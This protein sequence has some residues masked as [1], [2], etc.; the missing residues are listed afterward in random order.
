MKKILL[1]TTVLVGTAGFA[2]AEVSLSGNARMGV[3]YDEGN[4]NNEVAFNSRV[5]ANVTMSGET[6]GGLSFGGTFGIHDAGDAADGL[7]GTV[8]ISGAF[9]KLAMGDTSSAAE[10]AVGDFVELGYAG[11]GAGNENTFISTGDNEMALYTYSAGAITFMASVGQPDNTDPNPLT[12]VNENVGGDNTTYSVAV[13][14]DTDA[15][16]VALGY[17]DIGAV[18]HIIGAA[19]ATFSG[20]TVKAVYGTANDIDFDQYGLGMSYKMDAMTLEAYYRTTDD[21]G[22]DADYY[23]IG[24]E[25]D[26][27]GGAT[28]AGGI[29]DA[30]GDTVADLGVKFSF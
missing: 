17:E 3:T 11:M 6:D 8:Y 2:A 22:T 24:A 5:R 26:L 27:G 25:Y 15:F 28:L 13:K 23:G 16:S 4:V 21:A 14:Y 1:A 18:D 12:L 10:N 7:A 29:G 20:V 30:D 9:G 19:T